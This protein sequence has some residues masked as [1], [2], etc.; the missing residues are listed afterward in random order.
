MICADCETPLTACWST[1]NTAR[2][3]YYLCPK[4][5]CASYGKSTRRDKIEGEFETLLQ[6]VQPTEGLFRVARAMFQDAW[7]HRLG[8]AETQAKALKAQ[9]VKIEGQVSQLLTRILDTSVPSIIGAYEE[10]VSKL[11]SDKLLIKERLSS[12]AKPASTF[13]DTLRTALEFLANPCNLWNSERLEDRRAVLKLTFAER[14][15]YKRNEGF[16]TANLSLPFKVL[17]DFLGANSEM[18]RSKR[19]ELLTPRFVVWCSIQLS[20]ERA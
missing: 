19:F 18:A 4:R 5:G 16:R 13:D 6:S 7:T 17:G 1:G 9:L 3:P 15:R 8:Q 14:L 11:E 10:K 2:H 12:V 20:Y